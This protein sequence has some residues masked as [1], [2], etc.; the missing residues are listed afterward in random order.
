MKTTRAK[1]AWRAL[2]HLQVHPRRLR[3][4]SD[5][6]GINTRDVSQAA[7]LPTSILHVY[8]RHKTAHSDQ[9]QNKNA[10]ALLDQICHSLTPYVLEQCF[11]PLPLSEDTNK[12]RL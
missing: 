2:T 5:F 3:S 6:S 7:E 4:A 10:S 8:T 11:K 12:V 9:T 1:H